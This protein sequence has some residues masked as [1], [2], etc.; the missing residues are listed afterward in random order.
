MTD[1]E[2]LFVTE[3]A[4]CQL[5][6]LPKEV[7][8]DMHRPSFIAGF[9]RAIS[10]SKDALKALSISRTAW[11][12][13]SVALPPKAGRYTVAQTNRQGKPMVTTRKFYSSSKKWADGKW[14]TG[15]NVYAWVLNEPPPSQEKNKDL[16]N[17]EKK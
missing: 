4:E 10:V 5:Q 1:K 9:V 14:C 2:I 15:C 8:R 6:D 12:Y 17:E 3:L 13:C 11:V 16:I 7:T